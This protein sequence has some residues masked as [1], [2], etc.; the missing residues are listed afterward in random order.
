MKTTHYTRTKDGKYQM[1]VWH[2]SRLIVDIVID[3]L[4]LKLKNLEAPTPDLEV[5]KIF[6]IGIG[7]VTVFDRVSSSLF[8][9]GLNNMEVAEIVKRINERGI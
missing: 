8:A 7:K 3:E 5:N 6:K 4:P 1:R 9:L 2:L